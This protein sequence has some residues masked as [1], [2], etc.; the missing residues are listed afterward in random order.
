MNG[1]A[2][3]KDIKSGFHIKYMYLFVQLQTRDLDLANNMVGLFLYYVL[4]RQTRDLDLANTMVGL[5]L[6]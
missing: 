5:F 2:A 4:I 3:V 6:H 1:S